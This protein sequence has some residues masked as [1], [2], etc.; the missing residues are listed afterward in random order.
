MCEDDAKLIAYRRFEEGAEM[1]GDDGV[2]VVMNLRCATQEATFGLSQDGA[3]RLRLNIDWDG[4]SDDLGG[5]GG[6][7]L[8]PDEAEYDRRPR[9]ATVSVPPYC[10][11]L[12]TRSDGLDRASTVCWLGPVPPSS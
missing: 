6:G 4:Y 12:F 7:D 8:V 11:L 2:L 10:A 3:W 5:H 1:E 9:R